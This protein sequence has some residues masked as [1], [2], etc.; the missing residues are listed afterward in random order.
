MTDWLATIGAWYY[1]RYVYIA[2]GGSITM[3]VHT[4]CTVCTEPVDLE[5]CIDAGGRGKAHTYYHHIHILATGNYRV[6][7][8]LINQQEAAT[9]EQISQRRR[10]PTVVLYPR[11]TL[12]PSQHQQQSSYPRPIIHPVMNKKASTASHFT[13]SWDSGP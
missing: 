1:I 2:G 13:A 9:S 6:Q 8:R 4:Y 5:Q 11:T 7:H 10:G 12:K 3:E